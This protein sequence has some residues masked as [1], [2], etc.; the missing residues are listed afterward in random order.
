[1]KGGVHD[2][3]YEIWMFLIQKKTERD[4]NKLKILDLKYGCC[5]REREKRHSREL[6]VPETLPSKATDTSYPY[7]KVS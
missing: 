3:V 2:K 1:M 7:M 4:K 5:V 6:G